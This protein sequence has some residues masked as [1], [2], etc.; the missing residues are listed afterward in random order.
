M[1]DKEKEA[2]HVYGT[3]D[4]AHPGIEKLFERPNTYVGGKVTLLKKSVKPFPTYTFEPTETR[5]NICRKRLENNCWFP[6]KKPG[7]PCT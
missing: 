7:S 5:A 4:K 2:V 1:P 3:D 6:N